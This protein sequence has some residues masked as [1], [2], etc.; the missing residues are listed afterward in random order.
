MIAPDAATAMTNIRART[1]KQMLNGQTDRN[2]TISL[3]DVLY[4]LFKHKWKIAIVGTLIVGLGGMYAL[5]Q[6]EEYTS[7]AKLALTREKELTVE[8]LTGLSTSNELNTEIALMTSRGLAEQIVAELGPSTILQKAPEYEDSISGRVR[9]VVDVSSKALLALIDRSKRAVAYRFS[10]ERWKDGGGGEN[11][12]SDANLFE[13]AIERFFKSLEVTTQEDS[14]VVYLT[15]TGA[16][17]QLAQTVLE[18][19]VELYLKR[20]VEVHST[21]LSLQYLE[22]EARDLLE[23]TR[24]NEAALVEFENQVGL[25]DLANKEEQLI[26]R[27]QSL[28]ALIE[29]TE[30]NMAASRAAIEAMSGSLDMTEQLRQERINLQ[31][32]SARLRRLQSQTGT[33]DAELERN[34]ELRRQHTALR[35]QANDARNNYLRYVGRLEQAQIATTVQREDISNMRIIEYPTLQPSPR[36]GTRRLVMMIAGIAVVTS[37]SL[38]FGLEYLNHRVKRADE[39]RYAL[40]LPALGSVPFVE[41][42]GRFQVL[43]A[44]SGN[45]SSSL[46]ALQTVRPN[47]VV[48]WLLAYKQVRAAFENVRS[49][50]EVEFAAYAATLPFVVAITSIGRKE[51]VSSVALGLAYD[52]ATTG[53]RRVCCLDASLHQQNDHPIPKLFRTPRLNRLR[54]QTRNLP[55]A[56]RLFDAIRS[57]SVDVVVVDLPALSEGAHSLS[58]AARADATIVVVESE[59]TKIEVLE[60]YS[61]SL[62]RAGANVV[63][64]VLTKSRHYVPEWIYRRL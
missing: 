1:A 35:Q 28:Q 53:V 37:F 19:T 25:A 39:V 64:V 24:D 58:A 62:Q 50:V 54:L 33:I 26:S 56:D 17:P 59:R 20:H 49:E 41:S 8:S 6:P 57:R 4:V 7:V 3:R 52:L 63:G 51:G 30:A 38:A 43:P 42:R 12:P 5:I 10:I 2:S 13:L 34:L 32:E 18:K 45:G 21:D 55:P 44:P 47:G 15:Y 60:S 11:T 23:A 46:P 40:R 14:S 29:S 36:G 27:M 61:D 9:E 16:T 48:S 31:A 22:Q